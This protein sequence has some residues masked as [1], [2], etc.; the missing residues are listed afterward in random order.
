MSEFT[1]TMNTADKLAGWYR[2][3]TLA[4]IILADWLVEHGF[5]GVRIGSDVVAYYRG[6]R[7]DLGNS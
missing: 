7:F 1:A 5:Y 3:G 2:Q 4:A 6:V